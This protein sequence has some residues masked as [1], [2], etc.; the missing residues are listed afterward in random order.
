ML[1]RVFRYLTAVCSIVSLLN[2]IADAKDDLITDCQVVAHRGYSYLAPENTVAAINKAVEVGS[3]GSEFDVYKCA[4]GEVVL[5]HDSTVDRTTD[6]AY[7]GS[8]T[9]LTLTQLKTLDAGAWKNAAYA[10]EQ[11]PTM[12]E[13]LAALKNTGT[14]A[15]CEIKQ[16]GIA[17]EVYECMSTAG[18][19]D[20]SVVISFTGNELKNLK[21]Y[22]PDV[23]TGLLLSS[24]TGSTTAAKV[25]WAQTQMNTYKA[26]FLDVSYAAL[27]KELVAAFHEVDVPIWAWTVD[28]AA[29]I[30]NMYDW[31][32][33]SVTTNRPDLALA[34]A[35]VP[36]PGAMMLF[37][38]ASF[39]LAVAYAWTNRVFHKKQPGDAT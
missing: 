25:A 13:A 14:I 8:V 28:A 5:M 36:E 15:V 34:I 3:H 38:T 1:G 19:L 39:S 31:G 32:V 9:S 29:S 17:D 6:G 16:S 7:T 11:V 30:E 20:Q 10:G 35:P 33:V 12:S 2:H 21:T 4:S 22:A 26:D 27:T 23:P 18:M 24:F 37:I